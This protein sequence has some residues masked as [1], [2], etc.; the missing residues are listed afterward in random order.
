MYISVCLLGLGSIT[1]L[2]LYIHMCTSSRKYNHIAI[3][4]CLWVDCS[5]RVFDYLQRSSTSKVLVSSSSSHDFCGLLAL[6]VLLD[7]VQ[8]VVLWI[9][10]NIIVPM[11]SR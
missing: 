9:Y 4:K 5:I 3:Y 11:K 10:I 8:T 7:I 2:A 1:I 6:K